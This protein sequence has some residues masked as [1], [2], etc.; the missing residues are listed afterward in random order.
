MVQVLSH[1]SIDPLVR[2]KLE[3]LTSSS[4]LLLQVSAVSQEFCPMSAVSCDVLICSYRCDIQLTLTDCESS[5]NWQH[6]SRVEKEYFF[7]IK[8]WARKKLFLD[9]NNRKTL[10][11]HRPPPSHLSFMARLA[12]QLVIQPW[13]KFS[14]TGTLPHDI[15]P[16]WIIHTHSCIVALI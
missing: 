2:I 5:V 12:K 9:K 4:S 6:R 7:E 13:N 1:L 10:G 3:M 15:F 8:T 11:R 14:S 16:N